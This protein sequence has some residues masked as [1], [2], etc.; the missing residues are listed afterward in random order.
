M[1][2][3]KFLIPVLLSIIF[4]SL[5]IHNKLNAVPPLAVL[6][7]FDAPAEAVT[8]SPDGDWMAVG[9][10]DNAVRVWRTTT[11]ETP[12]LLTGHKDWVT[13]VAFNRNGTLIASGTRDNNVYLWNSLTGQLIRIMT[14]HA[15]TITSVA[16]AAD[17]SFVAS[18]SRDGTIELWP[19]IQSR[20]VIKLK[21]SSGTI[22]DLKIS[23]DG[24]MLASA[25][26]DGTIWLWGT[27]GDWVRILRGHEGAADSLAFSGDGATLLSGGKDGT[28]RLWDI[29]NANVSEIAEPLI[30]RGHLGA[31]RGVSFTQDGELAISASLDGSLR[32][33]NIN[34]PELMGEELVKIKGDGAPLTN[35]TVNPEGTLAAS[36]G[37]DGILR[38]W[39]LNQPEI[40]EAI[41][42]GI[43]QVI[44]QQPQRNAELHVTRATAAS[45]APKPP[46][47][48]N[49]PRL[50]IPSASINSSI[51]TFY[52][53]GTSW[54]ITPWERLVGHLQGTAWFN[55]T[56]NVVLAGHSEYPDGSA[57]IFAGLYRVQLGDEI[58]VEVDNV[59]RRYR[60]VDIR[61]VRY[62][63]LSVVSPTANNRLTLITC[64][65]PSFEPQSNFYAE[66]LIVVADEIYH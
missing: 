13:S 40:Q 22:H 60:V 59:T 37:T 46:T 11:G 9:G 61:T 3:I 51:K 63:D 39:N 1:R 42:S 55:N 54:A 36:V 44:R 56:G 34:D 49:V 16:F 20:Q 8:F 31:V 25:G 6:P 41:T 32:V 24:T 64:D 5:F 47:T 66:R 2:K 62:D 48:T 15:D 28:V 12:M 50:S 57:G 58:Q 7:L 23:P 65:I 29:D 33:W 53:D 21:N 43:H 38:L 10:R 17:D 52:L 30:M 19:M 35:L 26:D 14:D 4:I 45:I 27:K 18:G